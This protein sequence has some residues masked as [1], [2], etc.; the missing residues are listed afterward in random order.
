MWETHCIAIPGP[1]PTALDESQTVSIDVTKA[2]SQ[3]HVLLCGFVV[4]S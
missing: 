4:D 2:L 1:F 3:L